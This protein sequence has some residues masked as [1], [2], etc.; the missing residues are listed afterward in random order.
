MCY[1]D[2]T[3]KVELRGDY[4]KNNNFILSKR[5][6]KALKKITLRAAR[7]NVG[8]TQAEAAKKLNVS[9]DTISNW[10]TA[11]SFPDAIKIRDIERVYGVEYDDIIFL[12]T[13]YA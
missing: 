11:K 8:L 4:S 10:E 1:T 13:N 7:S 2:I 5:R 6:V 3:L 9:R 12:P